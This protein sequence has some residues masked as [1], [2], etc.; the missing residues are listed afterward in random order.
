MSNSV[1]V[2]AKFETKQP[3]D[4]VA[5]QGAAMPMISILLRSIA[6]FAAVWG[7]TL[8]VAVFFQQG[9]LLHWVH[10]PFWLIVGCVGVLLNYLPI[11][12]GKP[13]RIP[14]IG[15]AMV[16]GM[17]GWFI[18]HGFLAGESVGGFLRWLQFGVILA[19]V[20]YALT[21]F[22]LL[23]LTY[24]E[25]SS[26]FLLWLTGACIGISGVSYALF[27]ANVLDESVAVY[28]VLLVAMLFFIKFALTVIL[29]VSS[30]MY[31]RPNPKYR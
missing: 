31:R 25:S 19:V 7:V 29:V 22:S 3:L 2:K 1:N 24:R 20:A 4:I 11:A 26:N 12:K 30:L 28:L 16:T 15:I 21:H 27:F 13:K 18:A 23:L 14:Q 9:F 6:G 10:V 17:T 8:V 5:E